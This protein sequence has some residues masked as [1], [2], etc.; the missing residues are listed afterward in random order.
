LRDIFIATKQMF[1]MSA[2]LNTNVRPHSYS[3][4]WSTHCK[5]L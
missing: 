5:I 3:R 2:H 4:N 1:I